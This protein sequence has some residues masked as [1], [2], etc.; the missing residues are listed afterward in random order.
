MTSV[1]EAQ[2]ATARFRPLAEGYWTDVPKRVKEFV[3]MCP[4]LT[5]GQRNRT[6]IHGALHLHEC[7]D[8]PRGYS[9]PLARLL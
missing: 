1:L 4:P 2:W 3:R 6:V 8:S 7:R 5:R 9:L